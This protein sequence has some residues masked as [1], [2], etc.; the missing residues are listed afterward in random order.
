MAY[1][2]AEEIKVIRNELKAAFPAKEG[3]KLSVRGADYSS[4]YV[5]VINAPYQMVADGEHTTDFMHAHNIDH[6]D[7]FV[8]DRASKDL[9]KMFKII[10]RENYDNSDI[11]TDYFD[12]GYYCH[13]SVGKWDKPFAIHPKFVKTVEEQNEEVIEEAQESGVLN[14]DD[15]QEETTINEV[16]EKDFIEYFWSFYGENGIYAIDGLTE[17]EVKA[18]LIVRLQ[19]TS[20]PFHGDTT[21]R[22]LVRD[23]VLE[24]RKETVTPKAVSLSPIVAPLAVKKFQVKVGSKVVYSDACNYNEYE[25]TGMRLSAQ[26][27]PLDF[28]I[29]N[30]ETGEERLGVDFDTLQYGWDLVEN[31][32]PETEQNYEM[33]EVKEPV[34]V[35]EL[36]E[37]AQDILVNLELFNDGTMNKE[38][39]FTSNTNGSAPIIRAYKK[40]IINDSDKIEFITQLLEKRVKELKEC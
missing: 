36:T 9:H 29:I 2:N 8:D 32:L 4:I 10:N 17:N 20:L 13:L 21:D 40:V 38:G 23:I 25:V 22:E 35:I 33:P 18:A 39:N 11:M 6:C 30:N 3:W 16:D 19:D 37:L 12:V 5:A 27:V 7:K 31:K 34:S 15:I 28:D 24:R 14:L 1:I 26:D